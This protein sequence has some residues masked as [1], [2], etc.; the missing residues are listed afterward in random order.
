MTS[1]PRL[2]GDIGSVVQEVCA[3]VLRVAI[4]RVAPNRRFV[5]DLDV[6]SLFLVQ[7]AIGIEERFGIQVP[8]SALPDVKTVQHLIDFVSGQIG[9]GTCPDV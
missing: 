4:D 7:L 8:E 9:A 1:Q 3:D 5:E 6:D 2:P